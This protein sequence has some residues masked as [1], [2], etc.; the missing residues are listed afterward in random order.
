MCLGNFNM[1]TSTQ[2]TRKWDY[3]ANKKHT[4]LYYKQ[5]FKELKFITNLT[6]E[7]L[8]FTQ[9]YSFFAFFNFW[10]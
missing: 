7:M 4:K 3:K 1:K 10:D 2:L 9:C 5:Y 8:Y 6:Y